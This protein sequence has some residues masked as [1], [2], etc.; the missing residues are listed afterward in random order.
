[1]KICHTCQQTYSHDLEFC[2]R[3]GTRL[4]AQNRETEAQLAAGLSRRYRIVRRLGTGGMGTVFLVEQ[5]GVGNRPVALKVL[6]RKLL[7]SPE[8]LLRFQH[9][10][11]STGRISHV[12]VVTIYDETAGYRAEIKRLAS[13]LRAP[14][15]IGEIAWYGVNSGGQ[16]HAVGERRPNGFGLFDMLGNVAE[17]VNDW[18]DHNY[19]QVSPSQD[20][21]GPSAGEERVLR[22]GSWCSYSRS[23]RLS[24]RSKNNPGGRSVNDGFRCLWERGGP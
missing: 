21:P 6:N 7:D 13:R 2:P 5:I 16:A 20:P 14:S 22:G 1:M 15:P 17:W 8:F 24:S 23:A 4:A 10:A 18:Y 11:G 3:D 12:N 19:Y 9:E